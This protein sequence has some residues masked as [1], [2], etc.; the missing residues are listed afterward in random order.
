MRVQ[1]GG[2]IPA[3]TASLAT[4]TR[5]LN[6]TISMASAF[7]VGERWKRKSEA[8]RIDKGCRRPLVKN[9]IVYF[10]RGQDEGDEGAGQD[11]VAHQREGDEPEG[12]PGAGA[13]IGRRLLQA[14][15]EP[16]QD[17]GDDHGDERQDHQGLRDPDQ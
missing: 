7:R 5:T 12:L 8:T 9:E 1:F 16:E 4:M 10:G 11:T 14:P 17:R 6:S 15:V 13:E 2:R 3:G